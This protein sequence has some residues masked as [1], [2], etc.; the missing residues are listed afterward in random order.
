MD[1][2]AAA[3]RLAELDRELTRLRERCE[4]EMSAFKFDEVKPLQQRIAA[5]EQEAG[6]LAAQV[7]AAPVMSPAPIAIPGAAARPRRPS[8]RP[9][10]KPWRAVPR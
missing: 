5:L 1:T 6:R 7:P 3:A 10:T 4:L 9:R 8:A 2:N